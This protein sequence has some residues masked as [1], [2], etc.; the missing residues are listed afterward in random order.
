MWAVLYLS[1][2]FAGAL[3]VG[4]VSYTEAMTLCEEDNRF[5]A[6]FFL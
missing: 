3:V 5:F 1:S 6:L 4:K 2:D